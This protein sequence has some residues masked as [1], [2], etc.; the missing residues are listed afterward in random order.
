MDPDLATGT[1][2]ELPAGRPKGWW[3]PVLLLTL[4]FGLAIL[5]WAMDW[6]KNLLHLRA[7]IIS[8]GP[9]APVAFVL[10]R[11]GAAVALV[12]GSAISVA[13]GALFGP[14][15][16]VIC[17]SLGKTLGAAVAYLIARY[18]ARDAV[19]QWLARKPRYR[20]FDE[21]VEREGVLIVAI[22]RLIPI[23]PFNMQ[24]YAFGLT[25]VRF[26]QYLFWSWLCMLPGA[27]FVVVGMNVWA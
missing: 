5:A 9:I 3:R 1:A 22:A 14:V 4:M 13:G 12:P 27:V 10:V 18:F 7:W 26:G 15:I 2:H 25:R 6:G 17:V 11:A 19:S 23:I 20:G 8:L 16:G 21:L 24:N